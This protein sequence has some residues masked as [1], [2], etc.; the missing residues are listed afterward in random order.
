MFLRLHRGFTLI[1]LLIVV[2]IIAILAAIAVPNFLEAQTRARVSR[3]KADIRSLATG[4]EA[5][6]V[7]W[8][9]YPVP[10]DDEGN[11]SVHPFDPH[12][13]EVLLPVSV[14]TPVAYLG[15]RPLDPF[16]EN[17][18][19]LFHFSTREYERMHHGD[20]DNFDGTVADILQSGVGVVEYFITSFGPDRDQDLGSHS[21]VDVLYDPTNGTISSGDI[22]YWG[23]GVGYRR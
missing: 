19:G 5:Y 4:V 22:V 18:A 7:D 14:T 8:S 9:E 12:P 16:A 11:P 20:Y 13:N 17:V 21:E 2:A 1:E 10:A 3:A 15:S 23:P 6:F